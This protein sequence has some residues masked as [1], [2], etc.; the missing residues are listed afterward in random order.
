MLMICSFPPPLHGQSVVNSALREDLADLVDRAIDISPGNHRGLAYHATRARRVLSALVQLLHWPRSTP[1]YLSSESGW[2]VLYLLTI[3]LVG[4]IRRFQRIVLH[5]HVYAYITK[6]T[7]AHRL[8]VRLLGERC[9]HVLLS[10]S[11][12]SLFLIRYGMHRRHLVVHNAYFIDPQFKPSHLIKTRD[13]KCTIGFIG[14]LE[15]AKGFDIFVHLMHR[16]SVRRDVHFLIAGDYQNTP[17]SND[18]LRYKGEFD[19]PIELLGFVTGDEKL[20]FYRNIDIL[21]FPSR[22]QNEASPMV[23]YEAMAAAVPVLATNV[24]AISD[25]VDT[26]CGR[27]FD[28]T[29]NVAREIGDAMEELLD[30]NTR[31]NS[32]KW[33]ARQRFIELMRCSK[34]EIAELRAELT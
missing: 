18:L 29:T 13:K 23:C 8:L 11:M 14:R 2:G 1:L 10:P 34:D 12:V 6:P 26:T 17:Y 15:S 5:H 22:Y 32:M 31:I 24:G 20:S 16:L 21:I 7:R 3:A 28:V 33:S 27:L 25:L 30:D 19:Y 4:R 9:I